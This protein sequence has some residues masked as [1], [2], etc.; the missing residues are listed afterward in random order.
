[1]NWIEQNKVDYK[2]LFDD[3]TLKQTYP[4][5]TLYVVATPIGNL[6]DISIR[7]LYVLSICDR[8]A[9]EDTRHSIH[10]LQ[11]Y[12]L[13]KPIFS[14]HKHNENEAAENIIKYLQAGNRVGLVSD[15]GTPGIADPGSKIVELVRQAGFKIM[16]LPGAS[17]MIAGLSVAGTWAY[18]FT[19][20][21]FLPSRTQTRQEKLAQLS[22]HNEAQIFYEAPHRIQAMLKDC[23]HF[24]G[25]NRLSLLAKELTK[26]HETIISGTL[27]DVLK[28]TLNNHTRG[29][30]V[31]IIQ[32]KPKNLL[33][34]DDVD[35]YDKLLKA[36]LKELPVSGAVRVAST[37]LN[38]QRD[39]LYKRALILKN[40]DQYNNEI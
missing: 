27:A 13:S 28:Q 40:K 35:Q 7:S 12:G 38:V 8:I 26:V 30:Y 32:G 16:P 31:I 34:E 10:L 9:A 5:S 20:N 24:F 33:Q 29:E 11:Q 21:G 6:A 17:A 19:F 14:A 1:M 36:L 15:A 18:P 2:Q 22:L 25:E 39:I 3:L 4:H 23:C 37:W